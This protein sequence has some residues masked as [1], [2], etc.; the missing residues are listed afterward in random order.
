MR[1]AARAAVQPQP[2][3]A[4]IPRRPAGMCAAQKIDFKAVVQ[5]IEDA[6]T[7]MKSVVD[8]LDNAMVAVTALTTLVAYEGFVPCAE[9]TRPPA[10]TASAA[11][12]ESWYEPEN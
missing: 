5:P 10:R 11:I 9:P 12:A 4:A 3:I 8:N 6:A 1:A 7:A 2:R